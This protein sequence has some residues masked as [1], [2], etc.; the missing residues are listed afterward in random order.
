[1]VS[2]A[3][4]TIKTRNK[5]YE[6]ENDSSRKLTNYYTIIPYSLMIKMQTNDEILYA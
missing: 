4:D 3:K 5:P 2:W 1:M 6:K